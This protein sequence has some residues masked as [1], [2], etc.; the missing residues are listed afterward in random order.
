MYRRKLSNACATGMVVGVFMT[1]TVICTGVFLLAAL[2]DN[3]IMWIDLTIHLILDVPGYVIDLA[4]CL[5]GSRIRGEGPFVM[6]QIFFSNILLFVLTM[7]LGLICVPVDLVSNLIKTIIACVE[8]VRIATWKAMPLSARV[9][10][11]RARG[12]NV[13]Q[14]TVYILQSDNLIESQ[15]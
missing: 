3:V 11:L 12:M 8:L 14:A 7:S 2:A 15:K 10:L 5:D 4:R 1:I 13:L 9:A 6:A